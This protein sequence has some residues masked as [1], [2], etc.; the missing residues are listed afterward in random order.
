[1]PETPLRNR[2]GLQ[3]KTEPEL[4]E[5]EKQAKEL[6]SPCISCESL[7]LHLLSY[8][9][10][11]GEWLPGIKTR[12]V[13]KNC[14]EKFVIKLKWSKGKL[15]YVGDGWPYTS[16][17]ERYNLKKQAREIIGQCPHC[18]SSELIPIGISRHY[19]EVETRFFC[20]N[21]EETVLTKWRLSEGKLSFIQDPV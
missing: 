19:E 3:F 10:N 2:D 13:C 16:N 9:E 1:M 17:R 15:T 12:F 20:K 14:G 5:F 4:H 6:V 7:D 18:Q 11:H 21:C 8:D